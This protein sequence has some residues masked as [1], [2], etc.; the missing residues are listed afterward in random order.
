MVQIIKAI[1]YLTKIPSPFILYLV[2]TN[3]AVYI[4]KAL[5]YSWKKP[6]RL[7][8][9]VPFTYSSVREVERIAEC[10]PAGY[11]VQ[12]S[13]HAAWPGLSTIFMFT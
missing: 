6:Y 11:Q 3:M 4:K 1:R 7:C 2:D 13:S 12:S 10:C 8:G 5:F 9:T